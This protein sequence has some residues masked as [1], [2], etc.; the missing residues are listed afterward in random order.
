MLK[1]KEL[2]IFFQNNLPDIRVQTYDE[3]RGQTPVGKTVIV[4][5]HNFSQRTAFKVIVNICKN[6]HFGNPLRDY[7]GEFTPGS[8]MSVTLEDIIDP[9]D[10]QPNKVRFTDWAN[11][12][13]ECPHKGHSHM[14]HVKLTFC[15]SPK[16]EEYKTTKVYE[17]YLDEVDE[18]QGK[19]VIVSRSIATEV[20]F[21]KSLEFDLIP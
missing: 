6:E 16:S 2:L 1:E 21:P 17:L 19:Q 4:S 8:S 20:S 10:K 11:Y 18:G 15:A 14:T 12:Y 5:L 7:I 3:I 13:S 9:T